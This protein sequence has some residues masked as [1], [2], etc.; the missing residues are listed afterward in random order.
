MCF[1]DAA[2]YRA[3]VKVL[4]PLQGGRSVDWPT[5][6]QGIKHIHTICCC[7]TET[8]NKVFVFLTYNF[9]KERYVLP[10]DDLK[11]ETCRSVLNVLV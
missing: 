9:I 8:Y 2:A 10:E 7:I 4:Y 1:G 11:I 3:Y 6:L 5:S